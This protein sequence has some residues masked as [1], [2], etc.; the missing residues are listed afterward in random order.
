MGLWKKINSTLKWNRC[1][2]CFLKSMFE[3]AQGGCELGVVVTRL[4]NGEKEN[5]E[6]KIKIIFFKKKDERYLNPPN[7]KQKSEN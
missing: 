1:T 4:I 7:D 3:P 5:V 6:N 2:A